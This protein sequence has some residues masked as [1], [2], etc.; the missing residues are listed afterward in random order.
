[1]GALIR[2]Y[3][4]ARRALS[5]CA[6]SMRECTF[7]TH[8][9][10]KRTWRLLGT[11]STRRP[12]APAAPCRSRV[13]RDSRAR[14]RGCSAS[15]PSRAAPDRASIPRAPPCRPRP[16]APAA[17]AALAFPKTRE[18]VAEAVLRCRPVERHPIACEVLQDQVPSLNRLS[19]RRVIA[20]L[21]ALAMERVG[22]VMEIV[23]RLVRMPRRHQRCRLLEM[24]C[25]TGVLQLRHGN[26]ASAGKQFGRV[27]RVAVFRSL[28][29]CLSSRACRRAARSPSLAR[30]SRPSAS[31][32][33][34]LSSASFARRASSA[35]YGS[36]GT[37][38]ASTSR[39]CAK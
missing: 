17:R 15:S 34:P 25:S 23:C 5:A 8:S 29:F 26:V 1:M 27:E 35:A 32:S 14:C 10:A 7:R 31:V 11:P 24:L 37:S 16:P 22:L 12:P 39:V 4:A 2:A 9:G 28:A 38:A 20:P 13:A 19:K 3:F 36:S 30:S 21:V 18:R 6:C 33:P